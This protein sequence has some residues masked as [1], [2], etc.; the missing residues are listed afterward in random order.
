MST[1]TKRPYVDA[2]G[3]AVAL[4][5]LLEPACER[6]LLAGSLRRKSPMVGDIEIVAIPKVE[7]ALDMFGMSTGQGWSL[8]D[9]AL[10]AAPDLVLRKD[11]TKFKQ[12]VFGVGDQA[13]TV[14]L[15]LPTT[16]TWGVIATIRT[17]C[18]EFS[19]WLVTER[20]KG[21]GCP[22]GMAFREGRIIG[23][24]G[25]PLSTP[26]EADVFAALELDWIAPEERTPDLT[27]TLWRRLESECPAAL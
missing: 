25:K 2:L 27:K 19:N 14:D 3:H 4:Q 9:D 24:D 20:R 13:I 5:A 10:S 17:G 7:E 18:A 22:T 8:L 15:F 16:E 12:F 21:G 26:E 1:T 23:Y 11:G 6:F